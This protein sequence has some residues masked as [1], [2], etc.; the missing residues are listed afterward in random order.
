MWFKGTSI[1]DL[2][3]KHSGNISKETQSKFRNFLIDN[4][5]YVISTDFVFY[6]R[7]NSVFTTLMLMEP[8]F[9]TWSFSFQCRSR[10]FLHLAASFSSRI[11]GIVD[12]CVLVC[13]SLFSLRL[14]VSGI[15]C[16]EAVRM[17]RLLSGLTAIG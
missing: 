10:G 16:L 11:F 7:R 4:L 1:T 3:V 17:L 2:F 13:C 14:T 9:T 15:T 5:N 8:V 6:L 12:E